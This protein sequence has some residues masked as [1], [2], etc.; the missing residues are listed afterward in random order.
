MLPE[1]E[2]NDKG[3]S[4]LIRPEQMIMYKQFGY[5]IFKVTRVEVEDPE[6]ELE[7]YNS[8]P[9]ESEVYNATVQL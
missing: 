3:V 4:I 7:Y 1:Y 8:L 5:K 2:A 9:K 6:K